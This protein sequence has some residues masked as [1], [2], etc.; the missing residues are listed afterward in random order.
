VI[1]LGL[2]PTL[3]LAMF[4]MVLWGAADV[5]VGIARGTL[6][7]LAT[8]DAY[9]GRLSAANQIVGQ[10]GPALGD[11]RGG[12]LATAIGAGPALALGGVCAALVTRVVAKRLPD[13]RAFAI[14]HSSG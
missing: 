4:V 9:R 10:G 3:S 1:A 14:G 2:A 11:L 8:P 6:V 7:Q 13:A 5:L 12:L